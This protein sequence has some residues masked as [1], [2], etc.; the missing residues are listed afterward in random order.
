AHTDLNRTSH[1]SRLATRRAPVK[2]PSITSIDR[3]YKRLLSMPKDSYSNSTLYHCRRFRYKGMHSPRSPP[4]DS[5]GCPCTYT[6]SG[7]K[8]LTKFDEGRD[9]SR[10]DQRGRERPSMPPRSV[11]AVLV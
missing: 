9:A 4:P 10:H 2:R 8:R 5:L 11:T 3:S 7:L 6:S 1:S